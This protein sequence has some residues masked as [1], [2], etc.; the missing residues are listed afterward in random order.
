[1]S[2]TPTRSAES[3]KP[4]ARADWR[5]RVYRFLSGYGMLL[6]LLLLCAYYSWV[7]WAEQQP[8]GTV[9]G[10]QVAAEIIRRAAAKAR[11]LIVAGG[12]AEDVAFAVATRQILLKGGTVVIGVVNGDPPDARRFLES[13]SSTNGRETKLPVTS[14]FIG[15]CA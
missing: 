15:F 1:M 7:T 12:S 14:S 10:Q 2:V 4:A 6:V 11:V 5:V 3:A 8:T 9:A 13:L